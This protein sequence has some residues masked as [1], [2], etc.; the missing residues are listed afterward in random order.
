MIIIIAIVLVIVIVLVLVLLLLLPL[1]LLMIIIIIIMSCGRPR[2]AWYLWVAL[3]VCRCLSN[4]ASFVLCVFRLVEDHQHLLHSSPLMKKT[5]VR[6][7]LSVRQVAPPDASS[8]PPRSW[9][10]T[11]CRGRR[12]R[13]RRHRAPAANCPPRRPRRPGGWRCPGPLT[14]IVIIITVMIIIII[15]II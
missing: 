4:A 1:L 8:R 12:T 3:L 5:C 15:M 9:G 14:I 13:S 10:R 2:N 11:G 6:Q 7:V